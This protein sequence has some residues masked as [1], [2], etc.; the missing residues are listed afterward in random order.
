MYDE[1]IATH[2]AAYRPPI[3]EIILKRAIASSDNQ[4][5]GLDIGCG[6]GRS[7]SALRK[8]C[9]LVVGLDPSEAMLRK[10]EKL[11]GVIY[12]NAAGEQ[13]PIGED[14]VSIVTIAGSLNYIDR[15]MLVIELK[16]VCRS[17]AAIVV[18]D[19]EID[20][21][22]IEEQL[23]LER[24]NK[25]SEY[26]HATN[27][28]G[29]SEVKETSV[30]DDVFTLDLNPSEVAHLLLSEKGRYEALHEKYQVQN[31]FDSLKN[32]IEAKEYIS[33]VNANIYYS[34]YALQ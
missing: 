19:F 10:V 21:S 26:D 7:S 9:H 32:E 31:L 27:L 6:T 4:R 13:I 1:S 5:L 28:C 22:N 2:Y 30:V 3:H 15:E 17:D 34:L 11:E 24:I 23:K 14:L 18:Y 16:R 33:S 8:Y 25:L 20:L 29:H 12:V